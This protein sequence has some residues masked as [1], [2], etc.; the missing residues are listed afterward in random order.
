MRMTP[1]ITENKKDFPDEAC[2]NCY[3][4]IYMIPL[5][6][7]LKMIMMKMKKKE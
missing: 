3:Y 7:M 2:D 5:M 4:I 1:Q 6:V